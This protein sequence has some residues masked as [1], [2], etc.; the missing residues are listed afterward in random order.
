MVPAQ[1]SSV[2]SAR[3]VLLLLLRWAQS[4]AGDAVLQEVVV[5]GVA[6]NEVL[7]EQEP[8]EQTHPVA[9]GSVILG[10]ADPIASL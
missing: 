1:T 6:L 9:V 7:P 3:W 5:P 4:N 8:A 10:T 2:S